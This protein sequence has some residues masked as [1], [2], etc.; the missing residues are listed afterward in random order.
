MAQVLPENS[1]DVE[2]FKGRFGWYAFTRYPILY[3]TR[4]VNGEHFKFVSMRIAET[5]LL[6][7]YLHYFHPEVYTCTSVKSYYMTNSEAK[8]LN[9]IN[10]KYCKNVY[11]HY[12]FTANKDC[13]VHLEDVLELY[14]FLKAC[15]NKISPTIDNN[16]IE[17]GYIRINS[18]FVPYFTK[19]NKKY[20]PLFYFEGQTQHLL[21]RTVELKNWDL[22]Y[23]KFCFKVMGI[24]EELYDGESCSVVSLNDIKTHY[25]PETSFEDFWP[26]NLQKKCHLIN[27][28]KS[29]NQPGVWATLH[30]EAVLPPE[31]TQ[32]NKI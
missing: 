8:L 23:L 19:D 18:F 30:Y 29:R 24:Y 32:K 14:K 20:L 5:H 27:Q 16:E 6:D 9:N 22:V 17:F 12:D 21:T 26:S 7:S 4:T 1:K 10:T 15:Y 31:N 28:R 11:G 25:P 2:S 13:I 3:I